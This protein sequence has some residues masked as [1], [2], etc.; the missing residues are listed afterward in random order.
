MMQM[1]MAGV[2]PPSQAELGSAPSCNSLRA[3]A[4]SCFRT[5]ACKGVQHNG[6]GGGLSALPLLLL[7]LLLRGMPG[8]N[9]VSTAHKCCRR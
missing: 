1:S 3:V 2:M 9:S 5:A 7:L 8:Y 4:R 6:A